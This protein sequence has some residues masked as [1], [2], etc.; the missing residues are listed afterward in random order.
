MT[1]R[2]ATGPARRSSSDTGFITNLVLTYKMFP[3]TTVS[4]NGIQS[5]SPS[6][7][8]SLI[9]LTSV[10]ANLGYTVNSREN[11][12]FGINGSETTSSGTTSDFISASVTYGY[13]LT[14]EWNTQLS[15]RY[16]HRFAESGIAAS[17]SLIDP[18]TGL[19]VP[20]ASGFGPADS[21]SVM[22]VVSR[23][24]SVLPDGY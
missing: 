16:L 10:G 15:Y 6:L 5:I 11:L 1:I 2:A 17:G 7:V 9:E 24:V 8:G 13:S 20:T 22:L 23:S 12:S 14:R 18:L 4:I 21:H 19:L 3:D